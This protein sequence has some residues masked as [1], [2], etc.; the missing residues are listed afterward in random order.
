MLLRPHQRGVIHGLAGELGIEVGER[1][2]TSGIHEQAAD[3]IEEIVARGAGYGPRSTQPFARFEDFLNN[4]PGLW[5]RAIQ[6]LAIS[7][8][9]AQAIRMVNAH[10]VEDPLAKPA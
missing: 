9:V 4:D 2:F 7:L 5:C 1:L 3:A 8:R 10:P 6:A